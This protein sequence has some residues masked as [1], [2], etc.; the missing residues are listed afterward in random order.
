MARKGKHHCFGFV[1]VCFCPILSQWQPQLEVM[2]V[3]YRKSQFEALTFPSFTQVIL[4]A[5]TS[6]CCALNCA[7]SN[8]LP[9]KILL[10][11]QDSALILLWPPYLPEPQSTTHLLCKTYYYLPCIRVI[12]VYVHVC[13]LIVCF[14]REP[15]Y[16]SFRSESYT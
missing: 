7:F 15:S 16:F 10:I 11:F 6:F 13:H 3:C 4:Q 2:G 9:T 14:H 5:P 8:C 1:F 12:C